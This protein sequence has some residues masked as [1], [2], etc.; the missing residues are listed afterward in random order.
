MLEELERDEKEGGP[1]RSPRLSPDGVSAYPQALREAI[2]DGDDQTLEDAL[3][4]PGMFNAT[5]SYERNGKIHQRKMN[6]QAPQVLAEGE[7][8]RY[9]IRGLC[10]RICAEGGGA[11]EVYRARASAW[12]RPESEALIGTHI[13]AERLLDDLRVHIGEEPS[14]LPDVNSGLSVR[15]VT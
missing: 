2:I 9:Y 11:V 12:V 8:N 6:R 15:L 14:L 13:D 1:Y 7:F 3:R 10:A 4:S 5:E